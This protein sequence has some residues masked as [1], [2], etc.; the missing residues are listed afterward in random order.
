MSVLL[1][2]SWGLFRFPCQQL[3]RRVCLGALLSI[4]VYTLSGPHDGAMLYTLVS[5]LP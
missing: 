5:A 1:C 3:W 4:C 2:T